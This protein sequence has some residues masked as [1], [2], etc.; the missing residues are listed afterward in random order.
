MSRRISGFWCFC[1]ALIMVGLPLAAP[2]QESSQGAATQA[3]SRALGTLSAIDGQTLSLKTDAGA[4]ITVT[5]ID[6]TKLLQLKPGEKDLKQATPLTFSDLKVGDRILA[7]GAASADG[8]SLQATSVIAMKQTDIADKQTRE[9][10]EW[11]RNGVGGL[12]KS[13]DT[14][15]GLIAITTNG[16]GTAKDISVHVSKSTV[17]RRYALDS[18]KFDDART[19]P[20]ADVKAG[21]Q[22][23]ARG[24]KSPDGT[25][26]TADEVVSGT[27]RNIAGILVSSDSVAGTLKVTDLATKQTVTLRVTSDSQVRK[28]PPFM[29]QGI[30]MRLKGTPAGGPAGPNGASGSPSAPKPGQ[31]ASA[32]QQ[33]GAGSGM[34]PGGSGSAV[35]FGSGQGPGSGQGFGGGQGRGGEFQQMLARMPAAA[36]SDLQKGDALMIVATEGSQTTPSTV[37][38]LLAGVEPILQAS[39]KATPD[40]IL[41]PWTLGAGGGEGATP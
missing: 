8:K 29:A 11:Q 2:A 18:V 34:G 31:G 28:L 30:A 32:P 36:V 26:I 14:G 41:S 22:L 40:M 25:E 7:R 4:Q 27:F 9:R 17:L 15:S 21:D 13:V 16:V 24:Q 3:A 33:Q 23:R 38:T 12:V 20:L 39:S 1:I 6:S 35:G 37:I 19:A 10:A 5:V